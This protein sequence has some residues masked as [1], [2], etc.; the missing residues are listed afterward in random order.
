MHAF[1][2]LIRGRRGSGLREEGVLKGQVRL[3]CMLKLRVV[4]NC[5]LHPKKSL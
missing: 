5:R 4:A 3:V 1:T 2:R